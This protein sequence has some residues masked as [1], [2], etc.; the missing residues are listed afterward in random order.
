MGTYY[1][2]TFEEG[3]KGMGEFLADSDA[4]ALEIA[5]KMTDLAILYK[6]IS[7]PSYEMIV[8]WESPYTD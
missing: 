8:L 5:K 4:E 6:E 3:L 7:E 1:Y 2:E